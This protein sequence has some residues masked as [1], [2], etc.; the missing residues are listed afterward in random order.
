MAV[1]IQLPVHVRVGETEACW[2]SVT[3]PVID[4]ALDE[5]T[6]RREMAGFLRAAADQLENPGNVEEVADAAPL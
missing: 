1:D 4:G 5:A 2:G 3:V 6:L